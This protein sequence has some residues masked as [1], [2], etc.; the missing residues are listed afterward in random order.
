VRNVRPQTGHLMAA[1]YLSAEAFT[2]KQPATAVRIPAGEATTTFTLCGL[3]GPAVAITMF[4]DLDSDGKMKTNLLGLPQEPWGASGKPGAMGP[5][6]DKTQVT[7]DGGPIVV[8]L[9]I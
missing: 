3:S 4:Q 7:R 6:W 9:S 2:S 1:A 5:T 8:T